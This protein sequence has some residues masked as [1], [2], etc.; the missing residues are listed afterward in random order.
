MEIYRSIFDN[1]LHIR[2]NGY[3]LE[4]AREFVKYG[5]TAM[6]I[7]NFPEYVYDSD[8]HYDYIYR[9]T[10]SVSKAV[11][12]TGINTVTT[13][14]PYPLDYFYFQSSGKDPVEY[15]KKGIDLAASLIQDEKADAM[16]EIGYP[17]FPV[18]EIVYNDLEKILE[19]ALDICKD[20]NIPLIL[21]TEDMNE[22]GYGRIDRI[23]KSHYRIDNVMKHHA[24][25]K[26]LNFP[27]MI[28]KSVVASRN[29]VKSAINSKKEFLLETDY[30]DQR[31]KPG[32][33]IP[34]F[35]VPKRSEM[36]KNIYENSDEIFHMIFE[37]IPF[38]FYRKEFFDL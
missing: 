12:G 6:N 35:S 14:G 34:A 33:V 10:I 4:A 16:G 32:K 38:R 22:N 8:S 29:N 17:H 31:E 1:F 13:I 2:R 19:Y 21:H 28:L 3:F 18:K 36:I 24:N 20:Y 11:S 23:V 27:D 25:A 9:E 30:T 26:D 15:M 5:G 37:E 7:V